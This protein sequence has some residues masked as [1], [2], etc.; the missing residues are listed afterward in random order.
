MSEEFGSDFISITDEEGNSFELE[1]IDTL[2]LDG[3][4]YALFLPADMDED[5]PDYGYIILQVVE[6]DGEEL[7]SDVESEEMLQRLY[8]LFM[9]K[10]FDDE[11]E[12]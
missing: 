1:V 6:E 5:D 11:D 2:E 10:L 4:S 3:E 12:E 9:E 7:F 8:D